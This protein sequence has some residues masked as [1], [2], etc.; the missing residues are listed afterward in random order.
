MIYAL[1]VIQ[2]LVCLAL[3]TLITTSDKEEG[4]LGGALGGGSGGNKGRYK[5][6]YEEQM[7]NI[8]KYIAIAFIVVSLLIAF[9][10]K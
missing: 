5:P 10:S 8:T 7:D 9:L 4:G 3:I 2:I 6:G 1:Y